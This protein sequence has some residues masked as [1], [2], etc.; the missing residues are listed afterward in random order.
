MD[1]NR[2]G[3]ALLA[4]L[5]LI[6]ASDPCLDLRERIFALEVS[7]EILI[8][9]ADSERALYERAL[10]AG[11]DAREAEADDQEIEAIDAADLA[12]SLREV[13]PDL[14][15]CGGDPA[16]LTATG[17]A[18]ATVGRAAMDRSYRL[19]GPAPPSSSSQ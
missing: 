11:A 2:R 6:G 8:G 4:L 16:R 18:L 17:A 1:E 10:K 19:R 9:R 12:D 5:I 15:A 13:A 7:A 14:V 3:P